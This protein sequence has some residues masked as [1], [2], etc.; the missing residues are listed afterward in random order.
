MI[1][2]SYLHFEAYKSPGGWRWRLV[3]AN[4]KIICISSEA[5]QRKKDCLDSI[6][7][8]REAAGAVTRIVRV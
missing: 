2:N 8:V 4:H 1:K 6:G 5:Y 7:L 3:A